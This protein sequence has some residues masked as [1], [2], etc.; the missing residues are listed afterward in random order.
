MY[1]HLPKWISFLE[2]RLGHK[3]APDDF[4]FPYFS[5]NGIP[6]PKR[7]M[8]HD[9]VQAILV[10]FAEAAGLTKNYTTHCF[11]RGGAQYRFMF[12]PIG[13]RWSLS[14]IRWW[15]GWAIGEHVS[16]PVCNRP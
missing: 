13:K 11:R 5:A 10:E 8:T 12:A 2:Y 16:V 14:I 7:P 1:T 3:L 15:G 9:M 4:V 6:Q